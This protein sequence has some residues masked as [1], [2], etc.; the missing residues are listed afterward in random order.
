MKYIQSLL[1]AA[2]FLIS[3]EAQSTEFKTALKLGYYALPPHA[4]AVSG[5]LEGA[6][7]RFLE[8]HVFPV[9]RYDLSWSFFPF[10]RV[11]EQLKLGIIDGA[12]LVAKTNE[13]SARF[14][15]PSRFLYQT[16]SGIITLEKGPAPNVE[17]LSS[18]EGL[19]LGHVTDSVRPRQ[20][21]DAGVI[22]E[23]ISGGDSLDRNIVKLQRA[24]IDGV[25]V[26]TVSH[27][28]YRL[29]KHPGKAQ[30]R[31]QT[32]PYGGYK[33]YL[34]FRKDIQQS[35]LDDFEKISAEEYSAYLHAYL[36]AA[37]P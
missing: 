37:L 19:K 6:A 23:D 34:V 5:K 25:F 2:L 15:Y 1:I 21:L 16:R 3:A 31:V 32:L 26:P 24:R 29:E 35:V 7:I 20:L 11:L 30:L 13:R 33:L 22:F 18:L 17:D 10:A 12:I 9:D 27:A 28:K 36:A 8:E 14:R 4:M